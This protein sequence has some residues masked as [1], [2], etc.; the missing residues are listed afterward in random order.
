MSQ[1]TDD[2]LPREMND[3]YNSKL[4]KYIY[5]TVTLLAMGALLLEL[6]RM[7]GV[8]FISLEFENTLLKGIIW[9]IFCYV[10]LLPRPWFN[11]TGLKQP[12][13][14][15]VAFVII[16]LLSLLLCLLGYFFWPF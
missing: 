16:D 2:V 4:Y 15:Y 13:R 5:Y 11:E 10:V 12:F 9:S 1:H 8:H 7:M 3:I 14:W 6:I